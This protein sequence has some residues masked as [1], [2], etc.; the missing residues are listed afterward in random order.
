MTERIVQLIHR[1]ESL[2]PEHKVVFRIMADTELLQGSAGGAAQQT[3][4][5]EEIIYLDPGRASEYIVAHELMHVIL[6]RS[7]WPQMYSISPPEDQLAKNIADGVDNT[8]D[9]YTFDPMLVELGIEPSAQRDWFVA[10]LQKWPHIKRTDPG[11]VVRD[12]LVVLEALL[13]GSPYR[14]RVVH[15]LRRSRPEALA[16]AQQLERLVDPHRQRTKT[17]ARRSL[18]AMMRFLDKWLS[19]RLGTPANL[20]ERVG[21]SP[22]F[23]PPQLQQPA[24]GHI[25]IESY[26][27]SL[28][29]Q[30]LWVGALSLK[31]DRVRFWNVMIL[32]AASEPPHISYLRSDLET[33]TVQELLDSQHITKYVLDS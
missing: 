4:T 33:Q 32:N 17:A 14:R 23:A 26:P 30:S 24:S 7:G 29:N 28:N 22:I 25:D 8:V 12:A 21:A 15:I 27:G 20:Q 9:Q 11:H 31:S 19:D 16:L 3:G 6:H 13:Y 2:K 1:A 10:E 5:G 18:I